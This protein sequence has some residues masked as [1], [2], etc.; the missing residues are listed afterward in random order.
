MQGANLSVRSGAITLGNQLNAP[1]K[2][3]NWCG[4]VLKT[5][6]VYITQLMKFSRIHS[7]SIPL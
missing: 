4:R 6:L 5:A 7:L 1:D 3:K 2:H